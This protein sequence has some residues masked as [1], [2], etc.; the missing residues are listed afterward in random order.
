MRGC[1]KRQI[2]ACHPHFG[3]VEKVEGN[4]RENAVSRV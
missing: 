4:I 3:T 1:A 2:P